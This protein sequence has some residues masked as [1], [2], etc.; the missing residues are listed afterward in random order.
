[1]LVS[2]SLQN[3]RREI[4]T[5]ETN[6]DIEIQDLDGAAML[7]TMATKLESMLLLKMK[8]LEVRLSVCPDVH[9]SVHGSVTKHAAAQN[10]SSWG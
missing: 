4:S 9:L 7:D 5:Y 8:A 3:Y 10:E 6:N 1:M 2:Y